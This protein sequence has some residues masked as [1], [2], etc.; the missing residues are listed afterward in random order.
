MCDEGILIAWHEHRTNCG[1]GVISSCFEV[2]AYFSQFRKSI[3]I[4]YSNHNGQI[5]NLKICACISNR[6]PIKFDRTYS[7]SISQRGL[8]L[9]TTGDGILRSNFPKHDSLTA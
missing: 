2:E 1:R 4:K 8:I 3:C 5:A 9:S 6:G 7:S